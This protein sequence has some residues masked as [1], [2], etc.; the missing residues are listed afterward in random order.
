MK[1]LAAILIAVAL[2]GCAGQVQRPQQP[3]QQGY[4]QTQPQTFSGWLNPQG[5]VQPQ[6]QV[7]ATGCLV[8]GAAGGLLGSQ[9][10]KGKGKIAAGVTGAVIGT[11]VGCQQ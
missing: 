1:T 4:Y 7:N 8:G 3:Y 5:Q 9:F 11:M 2:T 10:G 6:P